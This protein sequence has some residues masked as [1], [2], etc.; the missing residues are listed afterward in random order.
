MSGAATVDRGV[1]CLLRLA[2][3]VTISTLRRVNRECAPSS[4][5]R[6]VLGSVC[7]RGLPRPRTEA[8]LT[9]CGSSRDC[10]GGDGRRTVSMQ[11]LGEQVERRES[12]VEE[13]YVKD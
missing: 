13:D 11:G 4:A 5:G 10:C 6:G 2:L 7:L 9:L 12:G 1:R 8:N 3:P